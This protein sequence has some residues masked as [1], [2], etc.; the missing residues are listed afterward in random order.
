VT[1][2]SHANH[3][4]DGFDLE[5]KNVLIEDCDVDATDDAFCFKS[6]NPDFVIENCVIR[7]CKASSA[8]NFIKVG[9]SS[10]GRIR[11]L[12]VEDIELSARGVSPV[13]DWRQVIPWAGVTDRACGIAGVALEVVDGGQ[14]E[15]VTVRNLRLVNGVQTPVM[16]RLARRNVGKDETFLKDV[17]IENVT[18]CAV[19]R[20]A[21]SITGVDASERGPLLRPENI[22]IRNVDLTLPGGGTAEDAKPKTGVPE[23]EDCYPENR[24]F[25]QNLP[26]SGFYVRHAKNVK[27]ENVNIRTK[28]PDARPDV[29]RDDVL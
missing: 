7:R 12:I 4:N 14:L 22:T 26:A 9:T 13:W 23:V 21:S 15:G 2:R 8:C 17:L 25:W 27:L 11:N 5:A 18:G 6:D 28:T 29:V 19:S 24:M 3:N 10:R 20:I 16:I 1:I